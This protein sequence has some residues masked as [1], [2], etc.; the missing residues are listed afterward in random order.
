M[1]LFW[2]LEWMRALWKSTAGRTSGE[3]ADAL[4]YAAHQM[5]SEDLQINRSMGAFGAKL[6][7]N[8][9]RIFSTAAIQAL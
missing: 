1:N 7:S 3:V 8:N 5:L 2:A 4:L 9:M 6:L